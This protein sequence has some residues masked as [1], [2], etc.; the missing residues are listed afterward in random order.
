MAN[1]QRF[2]RLVEARR[3]ELGM[4][5]SAVREAGGPSSLT[6]RRLEHGE[7]AQPDFVT[8]GK[9]D[10]ALQW[11]PGS[12]GRAFEGGEP[13]PITGNVGS[14]A[15][16]REEP[17]DPRRAR[18]A[19]PVTAFEHGV[20]LRTDALAE[21]TRNGRALDALPVDLADDVQA[22]ISELR[23]TIDRLTRAWIIRLA[24]SFRREGNL[25]DLVIALDDHL[26]SNPSQGTAED[27]DDLRYLRWLA[28]YYQTPSDEERERYERRFARSQ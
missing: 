17:T 22:G 6:V 8:F 24:E 3:R 18:P 9:L 14:N 23:Y 20:V 7:I 28:G 1:N 11:M 12:A 5:Q 21:L 15:S 13:T 26:R 10:Q 25:A 19:Q 16:A 27:I 4:S 2:G